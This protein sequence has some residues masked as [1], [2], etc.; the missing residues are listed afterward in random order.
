MDKPKKG[1]M[2]EI[3]LDIP[4]NTKPLIISEYKK[5]EA[6]SGDENALKK[7]K[8]EYVNKSQANFVE[9]QKYWNNK[10]KV[11]AKIYSNM[12][13]PYTILVHFACEFLKD[14]QNKKDTLNLN[15]LQLKTLI[16]S[17]ISD[18]KFKK[19]VWEDFGEKDDNFL[20]DCTNKNHDELDLNEMT[21]QEAEFFLEMKVNECLNKGIKELNILLGKSSDCNQEK[22]EI[23][24]LVIRYA[25]FL[26]YQY[27]DL[28]ECI[29]LFL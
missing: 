2:P 4:I 17:K 19:E 22:L 21:S 5:I 29:L 20:F 15:D 10:D 14:L 23:K 25:K 11:S 16:C 12:R 6:K 26:N 13:K 8:E 27:Y 7:L 24:Y 18:I 1:K 9:A 3:T 28:D